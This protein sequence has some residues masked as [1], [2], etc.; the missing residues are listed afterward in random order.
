[1]RFAQQ[2]T[3]GDCAGLLITFAIVPLL[4]NIFGF[5]PKVRERPALCLSGFRLF[6][7]RLRVPHAA[8]HQLLPCWA[9]TAEYRRQR[10]F[11]KI[12]L[13]TQ[14][15]PQRLCNHDERRLLSAP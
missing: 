8:A 3:L 11:A 15:G 9:T 7:P 4:A 12:R 5:M 13:A 14:T 2:Y 6:L 10:F 1:M